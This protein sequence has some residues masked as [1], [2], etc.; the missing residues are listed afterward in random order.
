MGAALECICGRHDVTGEICEIYQWS[1]E[2]CSLNNISFVYYINGCS[3]TPSQM[4]KYYRSTKSPGAIYPRRI[5]FCVVTGRKGVPRLPETCSNG[6]A[7]EYNLEFV[8]AIYHKA[9]IDEHCTV[10]TIATN[11]FKQIRVFHG[12]VRIIGIH[13][14]KFI[15]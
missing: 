8:I 6:E 7:D 3:T 9:G 2:N 1:P 5:K 12:C 10:P 14:F 13:V 4:C 11:T 15:N